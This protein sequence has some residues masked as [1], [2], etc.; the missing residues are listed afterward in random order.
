MA[1]PFAGAGF[2]IAGLLIPLVLGRS[3]H[4]VT[5]AYAMALPM[6]GLGVLGY[7]AFAWLYGRITGV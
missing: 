6:L 2:V 5:R 4:V 7:V 3:R 1:Y